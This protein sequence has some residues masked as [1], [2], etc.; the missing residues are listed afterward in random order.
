[1][2]CHIISWNFMSRHVVCHDYRGIPSGGYCTDRCQFSWGSNLRNWSCCLITC[3]NI[4]Y[5][6]YS[7]IILPIG[8]EVSGYQCLHTS[9]CTLLCIITWY[10]KL[11][12]PILHSQLRLPLSAVTNSITHEHKHTWIVRWWYLT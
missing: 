5:N 11:F 7:G 10:N 1:M 3:F 4:V 12:N 6:F 2:L 9:L 8:L